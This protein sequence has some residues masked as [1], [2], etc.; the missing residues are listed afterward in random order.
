MQRATLSF[1]LVGPQQEDEMVRL[2]DFASVLENLHLAL[3]QVERSLLRRSPRAIYR[4]SDLAVGSAA[5]T[6][7]EVSGEAAVD[8]PLAVF[9]D[10]VLR[11]NRG[12]E[13]DRRIDWMALQRMDRLYQ[14][15]ASGRAAS[16]E[17]AGEFLNPQ[18]RESIR[19]LLEEGTISM[20]SVTGRLERVNVHDR[21]EFLLYTPV[22]ST[23]V[24]CRFP[25]HLLDDVRKA[26]K[27]N[28]TVHGALRSM[29]GRDVPMFAEVDRI[30]IHPDD[31]Q[32]PTLASLRGIAASYRPRRGV[33]AAIRAL[34][35]AEE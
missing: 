5:A 14:P 23:Y 24:R 2:G 11:L 18:F 29:L 33:V 1:R 13:I 19:R 9:T 8:S 30:E 35:D 22:G 10:T 3:R 7:E 20:G 28:V 15:V 17:I 27:R 16:V 6:I 12:V 32:L 21:S 31:D 25:N 26:I 34:R 4:I